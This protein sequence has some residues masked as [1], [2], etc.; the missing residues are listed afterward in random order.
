MTS[1]NGHELNGN[2]L[3]VNEARPREQH[4]RPYGG[5]HSSGGFLR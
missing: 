2:Q 3:K 4:L 5:K 1:L